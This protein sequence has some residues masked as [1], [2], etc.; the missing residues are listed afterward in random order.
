M[1]RG[2]PLRCVMA[3]GAHC[4]DDPM[5]LA[6]YRAGRVEGGGQPVLSCEQCFTF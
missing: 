2:V 3:S 4:N 6:L 5:D 1:V